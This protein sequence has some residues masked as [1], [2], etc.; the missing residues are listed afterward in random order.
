NV[1]ITVHSDKPFPPG[2]PVQGLLHAGDGDRAFA[3]KV[4][5]SRLIAPGTWEVR[6]RL[7][8][9]TSDVIA[10]FARCVSPRE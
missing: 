1:Q 6:G 2:A 10:S 9:A 8:T 3:I 4:T 5:N 7:V